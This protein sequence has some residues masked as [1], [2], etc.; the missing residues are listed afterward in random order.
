MRLPYKSPWWMLVPTNLNTTISKS[1]HLQ[2]KISQS[3]LFLWWNGGPS[4][5]SPWWWCGWRSGSWVPCTGWSWLTRS[6]NTR[7]C[8]CR[9]R[10]RRPRYPWWKT[11]WIW[12]RKGGL[13]QPRKFHFF[14]WDWWVHLIKWMLV[15]QQSV[16]FKPSKEQICCQVFQFDNIRLR[17]IC[18][19]GNAI[20]NILRVSHLW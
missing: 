19:E 17:Y 8:A 3:H 2:S 18:R 4:P 12:S 16:N 1:F 20:R 7:F 5:W 9:S 14:L 11:L 10:K 15:Y 13:K 6:W